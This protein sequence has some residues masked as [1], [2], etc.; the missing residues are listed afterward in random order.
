M[1]PTM[2][3]SSTKAGHIGQILS[4]AVFGQV[5]SNSLTPPDPGQIETYGHLVI[6]ILV[7][8]VTIWATIRKALQK[9]E[10]VVKVPADVVPVISAAV[11]PSGSAV[12]V[13]PAADG[14]AE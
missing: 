11:V 9:P 2:L 4:T 1:Q 13:T 5:V 7:A 3:F 8:A 14:N 12:P 10:S 6:Q